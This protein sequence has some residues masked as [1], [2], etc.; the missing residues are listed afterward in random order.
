VKKYSFLFHA[1]KACMECI[2][3][4]AA[5]TRY[6]G[7]VSIT[8]R[9]PYPWEVTLVHTVGGVTTSLEAVRTIWRQEHY[10]SA[11][12]YFTANSSRQ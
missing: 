10:R 1:M 7:V 3:R 5:P 6:T 4:I 12:V 8:P 11:R 9:P 2:L